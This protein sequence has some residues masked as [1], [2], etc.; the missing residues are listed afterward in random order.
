MTEERVARNIR[1]AARHRLVWLALIVGT[2]TLTVGL[3]GALYYLGISDGIT[4]S[5]APINQP[6]T[7]SAR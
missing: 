4:R 2:L 1:R 6:G 3:A 7:R 5:Q